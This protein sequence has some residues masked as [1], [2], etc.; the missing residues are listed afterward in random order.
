MN[1]A[2]AKLGACANVT[3]LKSA[4]HMIC[5]EY[6]AVDRLEILTA[7]QGGKHQALCFLR[8]QSPEQEQHI[9]NSLGVGRF[10]GDLVVV[11]DLK[12]QAANSSGAFSGIQA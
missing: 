5:A 7:R 1:N 3:S 9:M 6:G 2:L 4:L 8:M 10:A 12:S 11:V